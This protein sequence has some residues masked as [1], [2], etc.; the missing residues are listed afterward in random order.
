M[1]KKS[2]L[3]LLQQQF[4]WHANFGNHDIFVT[5]TTHVIVYQVPYTTFATESVL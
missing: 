2:C 5:M 3:K 4:S 1:K